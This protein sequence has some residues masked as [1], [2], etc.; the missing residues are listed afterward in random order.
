MES[1]FAQA[2]NNPLVSFTLLLLVI[3]ILPPLFER[4]RLPG[5]VGLLFA[6]VVLGSNGLGLLDAKSESIALLADIGKIYLMFVAGLEIDLDEFRK[7]KDRS[8]GFGF[9]T[10]F[11]PLVFGTVIGKLFGMGLN[12]SVLI[13]SLLASHTLLGYP[14]V[15]RLGVVKNEAV[16]V[17]IGATIFTDIAALLVL[18][19]CISIHGGEFSTVSLI[20]QLVTLGIYSAIVLFGID[21]L[22]KEYFRRTGDEQSN[23]FMFILLV[24][25]LAAVG[26][27]VINVDQIVG[28]FLAGLAVNDVVGRSPVEE[29]IEF[30]GST[31]F[32][33]CFFVYMG[34]LLD[35]PGFIKTLTTELPL[36]VAIV[37]GLFLSKWLAAAI[38][39]LLYNYSWDQTM[40]MWSLSLPQVAA[41]LAAALAGVN[42]ELISDSVFN[43]V[44]VLMLVT[45]IAGPVL[46]AQFGRRLIAPQEDLTSE[47]TK[48]TPALPNPNS[49][50]DTVVNSGFLYD[51]IAAELTFPEAE[52]ITGYPLF[53]V[54]V[55]VA[56]PKT[57]K[58]LIEMSALIARHESGLVVPLSIAKAHVQMDAPQLKKTIKISR[59][60]LKTALKVTADF[61]VQAKPIIRIDD[62]I[63]RGISRTAREQNA[64]LIVMGWSN[65]NR[66]QSRLFGSVTDSVFWSSHCSVAVV[67]LLKKPIDIYRILVPIKNLTPQTIRTIRFANIFAEANN[68]TIT[69]LH[70]DKSKTDLQKIDRLEQRLQQIL[71]EQIKPKIA[72]TTKFLHQDNV[73]AAIINEAKDYDMVVLRSMR[74]R[75]AGGLS[76][77]DISDR[78]INDIS[79]SIVLFGEPH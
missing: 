19:I 31:L 41:T 60:R 38:A 17:T 2:S 24:V 7:T 6:G 53:R 40:T 74:R 71:Q 51:D 42:A 1:V 28:A 34:L 18:A 13:G 47:E 37:G 32:I 63:V 76:V 66:L 12:A 55:P 36:T 4:I 23:Q 59:R 52:R 56:N 48:L 39:K 67:R 44:I 50:I 8:I 57:E 25:F 64:S 3:L 27:Q 73:A 22:G 35:I 70:I 29:K 72:I 68:A 5:L 78:V 11:V 33:P 77:S 14:I 65:V 26:A 43:V 16:T 54:V 10:F 58:Y 9:A 21:K 30:V 15:N 20:I 79:C 75:T 46:T 69:L 49:T 61:K 62:D 45:S